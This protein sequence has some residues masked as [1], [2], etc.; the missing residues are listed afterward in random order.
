M[1][2]AGVENKESARSS[3]NRKGNSGSET[4]SGIEKC[5][6]PTGVRFPV[7]NH[8]D[9]SVVRGTLKQ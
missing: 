5:G 3:D 6:G 9:K 7:H 8:P 4:V 2:K 1:Y